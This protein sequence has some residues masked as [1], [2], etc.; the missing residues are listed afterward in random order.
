MEQQTLMCNKAN[1]QFEDSMRLVISEV[2]SVITA[3]NNL[4]SSSTQDPNSLSVSFAEQQAPE[5]QKSLV[6]MKQEKH[7]RK[8]NRMKAKVEYNTLGDFIRYIDYM[9]VEIFVSL[10]LSVVD[11]FNEEISRARKSGIFE[12]TVR[13]HAKGSFFSPNYTEI[14]DMVSALLETVI[15]TVGGVNR[16]CYL[17]PKGNISN[18]QVTTSIQLIVHESKH[19]KA[20]SEAIHERI[21]SDFDKA[22]EHIQSFEAV[23]PIYDFNAAWDLEA[24]R[25]QQ[26]DVGSLKSMM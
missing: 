23:R 4:F 11:A 17:T 8:L 2:Q 15:N 20:M 24:Y 14:R 13:F 22:E 19:Y 10:A 1:A 21:V 5:K 16:V 7:Q 25:A 9:A 3:I 18:G 6:Q 12:T 26:H